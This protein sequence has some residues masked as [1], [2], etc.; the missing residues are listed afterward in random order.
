[1]KKTSSNTWFWL[2]CKIFLHYDQRYLIFLESYEI[3][4]QNFY[5][6]VWFCIFLIRKYIMF[7]CTILQLELAKVKSGVES[8]WTADLLKN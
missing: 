6:K 3:N 1:M 8:I 7:R 4:G 2:R 5:I